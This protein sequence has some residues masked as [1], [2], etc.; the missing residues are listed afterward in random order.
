MYGT[1][2]PAAKFQFSFKYRLLTFDPGATEAPKQTLQFAYTQRS[3]WDINASSSPFY[4]T[5]YMPALFYEFLTLAPDPNTAKGGPTWLGLQSG[6]QH[7]SNGQGSVQSR[8]LNTMFVRS[9]Y[10]SAVRRDGTRSCWSACLTTWADCR[11]TRI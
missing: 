9:G 3:L 8:S 1:K 11:T 10:L 7:E 4:D 5:S 6:Y 2:A